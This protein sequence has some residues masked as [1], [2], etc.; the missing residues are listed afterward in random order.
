ML[1]IIFVASNRGRLNATNSNE[2]IK[3]EFGK[4]RRRVDLDS[5]GRDVV[6]FLRCILVSA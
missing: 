1:L 6:D 5:N 2:I 4:K 3:H